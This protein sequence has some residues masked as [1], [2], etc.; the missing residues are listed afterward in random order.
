MGVSVTVTGEEVPALTVF[1]QAVT[2]YLE[3]GGIRAAQMAIVRDGR[4]VYARAFT[5]GV[6]G[7][8]RVTPTTL[9]RLA[10]TSKPLTAIGIHRLM[11]EGRLPGGLDTKAFSILPKD[12]P[13]NMALGDQRWDDVTLD[14]L[15][16]HNSGVQRDYH[17]LDVVQAAGHPLPVADR[18]E[19]VRYM[20]TR[21]LAAAPGTGQASYSNVNFVLLGHVIDRVAEIADYGEWMRRAVFQRLLGLSRPRVAESL[22]RRMGPDEVMRDPVDPGP[23]PNVITPDG[24]LVGNGYGNGNDRVAAP[25]GGWTMAA[26]DYAK[27]L[28]ALDTFGGGL[29]PAALVQ[30]M[31]EL[32]P[33][34]PA[35]FTAARGWFVNQTLEAATP[36]LK[37]RDHGG[38]VPGGASYIAH[39]SDGTSFVVMFNRESPGDFSFPAGSAPK[40]HAQ[41]WHDLVSGVAKWPAHDLFPT[42]GIPPVRNRAAYIRNRADARVLDVQKASKTPGTP[43]IAYPR[44]TTISA[45]QTWLVKQALWVTYGRLVSRL[46]AL[47][48]HVKERRRQPGHGGHHLAGRRRRRAPGAVGARPGSGG[49][50]DHPQPAHPAGAPGRRRLDDAGRAARGDRGQGAD[51]PGGPAL[52]PQG[53]VRLL[54]AEDGVHGRPDPRL[55]ARLA[56]GQPHARRARSGALA[57][58]GRAC[59]P[60]EDRHPGAEPVLGLRAGGDGHVLHAGEFARQQARRRRLRRRR[61]RRHAG[62]RLAGAGSC[63]DQP[64]LDHGPGRHAGV[65]PRRQARARRRRRR[66]GAAG[67]PGRRRP[68]AGLDARAG[69]AQ[70]VVTAHRRPS[71]SPSTRR[72]NTPTMDDGAGRTALHRALGAFRTGRLPSEEMPRAAVEALTAGLDSPTLRVLAGADGASGYEIDVLVTRLVGEVGGPRTLTEA[73]QLAADAWLSELADGAEPGWRLDLENVLGPLG[74]HYRWFLLALYDIEVLHAMADRER[75]RRA[76]ATMRERAAQVLALPAP[77][78]LTA[79]S[80]DGRPFLDEMVRARCEAASR[81]QTL[82]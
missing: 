27:V 77:D 73:R 45:N 53:S 35:G 14:H 62:D 75:R 38:E 4:L 25:A 24:E 69:A 43:V 5:Y 16:S 15:L 81:P 36:G 2:A 54:H 64:S 67:H 76:A 72:G 20:R 37:V 34:V 29:F 12:L 66:A 61:Q 58:R 21:P 30:S 65:A 46:N 55:P 1:D 48:L 26:V 28:A 60:G 6:P 32:Q 31:W 52:G 47:T 82:G 51:D 3:Q 68:R 9:F 71:S 56:C 23:Y 79:R 44:G 33:G 74:G 7:V 49:G 18:A 40:D 39:R 41:H 10:S 63:R 8:P 19:V 70:G 57:R 80:A 17:D 42:V 22:L 59:L 13:A 11:H 50:R 78:R